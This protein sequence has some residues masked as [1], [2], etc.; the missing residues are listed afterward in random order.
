M[1]T[2][3]WQNFAEIRRFFLAQSPKTYPPSTR[4][5][6][7]NHFLKICTRPTC[8]LF[9]SDR[10]QT[11]AGLLEEQVHED[12]DLPREALLALVVRHEVA[13]GVAPRSSDV[14]R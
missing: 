5:C 1:L 8:A 12:A 13:A 2:N 6:A 10:A 9:A 7:A 4:G 14:A 11:A 3:F